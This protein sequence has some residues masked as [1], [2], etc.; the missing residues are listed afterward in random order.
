VHLRRILKTYAAYYSEVRTC[1]SLGKNAPNFRRSETVGNIVAMPI[2]S[3]LH[4]QHVRP[5]VLMRHS[6]GIGN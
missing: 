1:L 5:S 6:D 2:L 3:G 4:H